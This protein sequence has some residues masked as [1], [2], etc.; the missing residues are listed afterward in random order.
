MFG[1][2]LR[3]GF[4]FLQD[5]TP[6]LAQYW[7]ALEGGRLRESLGFGFRFV[8]ELDEEGQGG[9]EG[10]RSEGGVGKRWSLDT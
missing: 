4:S 10:H 8:V 9:Q 2:P 6:F 3:P 7:T 1:V 5:P